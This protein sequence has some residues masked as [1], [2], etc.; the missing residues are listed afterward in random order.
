MDPILG[1]IVLFP[2]PID[3]YRGGDLTGWMRCDGRLL[4]ISENQALFALIGTTYGG[5]G[6]TSFALPKLTAPDPHMSYK[7]ATQGVFPMVD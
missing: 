1:M 2:Y 5:D 7:I 3:S 6:R 4:Q